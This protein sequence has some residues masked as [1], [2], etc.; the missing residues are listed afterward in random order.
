MPRT[1]PTIDGT[2]NFREVGIRWIDA[3]NNRRADTLRVAQDATDAE[4]EAIVA[5]FAAKSNANIWRVDVAMVYSSVMQPSDAVEEPRESVNDN[6]VI[7]FKDAVGNARDFFIPAPLDSLFVGGTNNPDAADFA[8]TI[9]A[10]QAALEPAFEPVS[11]R[12][13]E[14][15]KKNRSVPV[16]G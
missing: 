2:G 5:D 15:R 1:V 7:L 3:N 14:R 10:L 12:F 11:L 13:T 9:A 8:A 4:I 6:I 16:G